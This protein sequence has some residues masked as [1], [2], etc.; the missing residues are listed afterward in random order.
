MQGPRGKIARCL[1]AILV[2]AAL[3]GVA[4]M[5]GFGEAVAHH[6][7]PPAPQ[8]YA[9]CK[10]VF[11]VSRRGYSRSGARNAARAAWRAGV[12]SRYGVR[13]TDWKYAAHN[14]TKC[15]RINLVVRQGNELPDRFICR[16]IAYPCAP[17]L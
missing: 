11:Q 3:V 5:S 17:W 6:A 15:D 1:A 16:A 10:P 2:L 14:R 9:N 4:S 8:R 12:Q 13:F 7:P